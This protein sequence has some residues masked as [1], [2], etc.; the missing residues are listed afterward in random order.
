MRYFGGSI[1]S[2]SYLFGDNRS[3]VTNATLPHSTLANCH[4]IIAFHTIAAK[5]MVFYWIKSAYT[6]SDMLSK[7]WDPLVYTQ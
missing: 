2:K 3:V 7:H 6:L 4:N 5:L 1:G